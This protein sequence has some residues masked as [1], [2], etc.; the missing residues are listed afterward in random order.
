MAKTAA[1]ARSSVRAKNS[2]NVGTLRLEQT[3]MIC[4]Q[5]PDEN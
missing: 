4:A 1:A 3:Q 5:K 2:E